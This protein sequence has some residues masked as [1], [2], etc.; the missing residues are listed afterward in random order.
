LNVRLTLQHATPVLAHEVSPVQGVVQN[1]LPRESR[2]QTFVPEQEGAL[3]PWPGWP[4]SG[5]QMYGPATASDPLTMPMV[6]AQAERP[7]TL[8]QSALVVQRGTQAFDAFG[9]HEYPD[10]Q[11]QL[12]AARI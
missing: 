9:S 7:G 8:A 1:A 10:G 6:G 2:A 11:Q 5:T 4:S 12:P 3:Q